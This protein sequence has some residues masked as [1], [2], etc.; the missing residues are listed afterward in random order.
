MHLIIVEVF[1]D[2]E[3]LGG[4]KSRAINAAAGAV[5]ISLE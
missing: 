2:E 5:I 1:E 4:R 3:I